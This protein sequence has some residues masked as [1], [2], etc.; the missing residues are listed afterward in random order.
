MITQLEAHRKDA[1]YFGERGDWPIVLSVHRDSEDIDVSNFRVAQKRLEAIDAD[2]VAVERSSHWACG[3][4]DRLLI[5]PDVPA[6][7]VEA[8]TIADQL[9]DYPIL[10]EDD[11]GELEN[12][13]SE[14]LGYSYDCY[15]SEHDD[16]PRSRGDSDE[17]GDADCQCD[18]HC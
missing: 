10:D 2:N 3:W 15:R 11:L 5:A 9:E 12:E 18:C 1:A 17:R 6:L 8:K 13:Q 4:I 16:C 14:A 7:A